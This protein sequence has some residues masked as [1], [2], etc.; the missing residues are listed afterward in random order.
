M[1]EQLQSRLIV[2][3]RDGPHLSLGRLC[4]RRLIQQ[5]QQKRGGEHDSVF[6]R[7]LPRTTV[8]STGIMVN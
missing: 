4:A 3:R 8:R 2:I 1:R 7:S 5:Q 6:P